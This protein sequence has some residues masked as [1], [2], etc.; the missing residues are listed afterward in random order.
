MTTKTIACRPITPAARARYGPRTTSLQRPLDALWA[1]RLLGGVG[2]LV[3]R[4]ALSRHLGHASG[5]QV[6]GR[7][8]R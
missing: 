8:C 7:R 4:A 1:H 5:S 2:R 6:M 3:L